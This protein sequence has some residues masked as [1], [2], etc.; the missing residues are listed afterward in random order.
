MR[1]AIVRPSALADVPALIAL[2][3]ASWARTY[4]P[5]IGTAARIKACDAKHVPALFEA[6]IVDPDGVSVVGE[7]GG[8]IVGHAGGRLRADGTLYID[9]L[10]VAPEG[11]GTGLAARLLDATV[12]Q[13]R[14]RVRLIELL[15]LNGNGRAMAFYRKNGFEPVA[16]RGPGHGL[17]GV[18]DVA[19]RREPA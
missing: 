10:H 7:V 13:V 15:V 9:R 16:T 2:T 14:P 19:M 3:K 6:E 12:D 1:E 18:G 5:I 17:G 8:R 4:D 11:Q